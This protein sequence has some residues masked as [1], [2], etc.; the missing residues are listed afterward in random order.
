MLVGFPLEHF[1]QL[2]VSHLERCSVR[3]TLFHGRSYF[4]ILCAFSLPTTL[5]IDQKFRNFVLGYRDIHLCLQR[6]WGHGR[7]IPMQSYPE[8]VGYDCPR[9]LFEPRSSSNRT[10]S[11]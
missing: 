8:G 7:S 4:Q 1:S 10:R 3:N 9:Y 5:W 6:V 2:M 11:H